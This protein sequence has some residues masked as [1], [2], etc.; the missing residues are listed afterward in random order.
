[1]ATDKGRL[2]GAV[3]QEDLRPIGVVGFFIRS[4]LGG[5][6]AEVEEARTPPKSIP[7]PEF[8]VLSN[9]ANSRRPRKVDL[10]IEEVQALSF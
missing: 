3:P 1:M 2:S 5:P 9:A 4:T 7:N 8:E 6:T 10:G